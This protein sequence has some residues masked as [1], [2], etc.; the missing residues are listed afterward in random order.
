MTTGGIAILTVCAGILVAIIGGWVELVK[1]RKSQSTVV[2]E[3][4][5]NNGGSLRDAV[6]R[7]ETTAD[8]IRET[9][10]RQGERLAKVEARVETWS[11]GRRSSDE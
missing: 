1:S 7:I 2:H 11:P 4:Q 9:Q 3:V 8:K 5:Q 10:V 6:N